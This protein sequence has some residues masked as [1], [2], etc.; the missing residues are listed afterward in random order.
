MSSGHTRSIHGEALPTPALDAIKAGGENTPPGTRRA[1][2]VPAPIKK[3]R[4][5][6]SKHHQTA[7][8][9][10]KREI[11]GKV[12]ASSG[13]SYPSSKISFQESA[14]GCGTSCVSGIPRGSAAKGAV[15]GDI[16][17]QY[18]GKPGVRSN[19]KVPS[20]TVRSIEEETA[21]RS[22]S[23]GVVSRLPGPAVVRGGTGA[24][25]GRYGRPESTQ[26]GRSIPVR[27][28]LRSLPSSK[29]ATRMT[30]R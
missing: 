20:R 8:T 18:R 14:V 16:V 28:T 26:R 3:L 5:F 23:M 7:N 11:A 12:A 21:G 24:S 29:E 1:S 4:V 6:T 22:S 30:D 15:V 2:S 10:G 13:S 19:T 17:E 27:S 25:Q 9:C